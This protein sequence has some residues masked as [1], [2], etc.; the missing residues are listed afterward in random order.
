[1]NFELI[2]RN[3]LY[4]FQSNDSLL[5]ENDL[6]LEMDQRIERKHNKTILTSRLHKNDAIGWTI[7]CGDEVLLF[8]LDRI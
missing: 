8:V 2:W 5:R 1:V 4:H 6:L 7:I 3:C